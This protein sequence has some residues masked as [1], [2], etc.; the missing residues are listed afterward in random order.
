MLFEKEIIAT[1]W[2]GNTRIKKCFIVLKIR[3]RE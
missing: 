2:H 1:D 3:G